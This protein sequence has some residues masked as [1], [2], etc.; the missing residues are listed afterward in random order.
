MAQIREELSQKSKRTRKG[1]WGSLSFEIASARASAGI[2]PDRWNE[3]SWQA[4]SAIIAFHR[5]ETAMEA[6]EAHLAMPEGSKTDGT[7]P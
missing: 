4:K 7:V 2:D 3:L 1:W 6:W 5:T